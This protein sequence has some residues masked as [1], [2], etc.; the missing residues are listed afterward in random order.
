[1]PPKPQHPRAPI[2]QRGAAFAE[3]EEE[4]KLAAQREM[5]ADTARGDRSEPFE[6]GASKSPKGKGG[7]GHASTAFQMAPAHE[8][9]QEISAHWRIVCK[10]QKW[11]LDPSN[12]DEL[13][14]MMVTHCPPSPSPRFTIRCTDVQKPR[15]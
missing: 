8:G 7:A 3:C 9:A 2:V 11:T 10:E 6:A 4:E 15:I 13:A 5:A 14:L 1:M 12:D